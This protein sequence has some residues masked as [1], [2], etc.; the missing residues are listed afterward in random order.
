M[1][2]LG[3]LDD[4][5]DPSSTLQVVNALIQANKE[6]E[7]VMLPNQRHT[8]AEVTAE[9]NEG[10]FSKTFARHSHHLTGMPINTT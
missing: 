2:I 7:F 4:N 9:E 3:E 1:L 10:F 6:F 8:M 5:V